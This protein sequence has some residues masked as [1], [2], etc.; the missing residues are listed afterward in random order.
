MSIRGSCCGQNG[1]WQDYD[2]TLSNAVSPHLERYL[3]A[4]ASRSQQLDRALGFEDASALSLSYLTGSLSKASHANLD[5]NWLASVVPSHS[6]L[7]ARNLAATIELN[8][9][10]R[11]L[12][13]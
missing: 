6:S 9:A 1:K 5:P 8:L 12:S 13:K 4:K 11:T 3:I 10:L 7:N 2:A